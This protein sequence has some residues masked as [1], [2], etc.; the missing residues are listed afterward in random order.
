[1]IKLSYNTISENTLRDYLLSISDLFKPHLCDIVNI[2]EYAK[3]IFNNAIIIEAW[4]KN[5]LIGIIACYANNHQNGEAYITSV[6]IIK[7][8]Q[9]KGIAQLMLQELYKVLKNRKFTKIN[10]EVSK[11]NINA[12]NLYI[13]EGFKFKVENTQSYILTKDYL[14]TK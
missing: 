8:Y 14:N 4:D 5:Q 6:S 2:K 12:L 10:L 3:K 1:M 9:G 7:E 13:K 11:H